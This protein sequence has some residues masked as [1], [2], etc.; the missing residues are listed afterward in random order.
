MADN[1]T[2]D[3][4]AT[5]ANY[6][7]SNIYADE[8]MDTSPPSFANTEYYT[9][10]TFQ[11]RVNQSTHDTL[12]CIHL[13]CQSISAHWDPLKQF[14]SDVSTPKFK[15][16]VIGLSEIFSAPE[17]LDFPLEGYHPLEFRTR[18]QGDDG[19]GGVGL[20]INNKLNYK[21]RTDLSIF[22]PHILESLFV[23]LKINNKSIIV[24]VIYRPNTQPK[25]DID[26]FINNMENITQQLSSNKTIIMGDFNIDLLKYNKHNKTSLFVDNMISNGMLPIINKPTRVTHTS[27]TIIDHIYINNFTKDSNGGIILTD[28][29]DHFATYYIEHG[30]DKSEN[31]NN[32]K[33]RQYNPQNI[34][35]FNELLQAYNFSEI[36]EQDCPNTAYNKFMN[37]YID[38]HNTA[39][40]LLTS[41]SK[42][43]YCK[44]D[45]WMTNGLIKS[46]KTKIKL[47]HKKLKKPTGENQL[48]YKTYLKIYN[49]T[50]R[51]A[52]KTY[53]AKAILDNRTNL[54]QTWKIINDI[55]QKKNDKSTLPDSF[56]INGNLITD[57]QTI[58]NEFN[59][60]FSKIGKKTN[61]LV[62]TSNTT[63]N[64]YLTKPTENSFFMNPTNKLEIENAVNHMKPKTSSGIDNISS[65]TIQ[66]TIY[67]ISEPLAH[68]FNLSFSKGQ[69]PT[70]MKTAKIIPIYKSGEKNQFNNYRPISLLPSVSKILEKLVSQRLVSF[71]NK[72]KLLYN[73]QYGFRQKHSTIHP[74]IQ[75]LNH[76]ANENDRPTGDITLSIF[77]DLSKA[78]DTIPHNTLLKKLEYYGIRGTCNNWFKDYLSKRKQQLYAFSKLSTTEQ[79]EC[80][81]PQG[82][83]LGPILF[84]I[85]IN[86]IHLASKFKLMSF[87]DDTTVFMSGHNIT[88]L[89]NH[90]NS[91]IN[92]L[93]VWLCANKLQLNIK[94]TKFAIFGPSQKTSRI[95]KI[96]N[97]KINNQTIEQFGNKHTE[98][99]IKFLGIQ[100]DE[101]LSWNYHIKY[102]SK[103]ISQG[104]YIL[105]RVKNF[106]PKYVL[107][108]LYYTLIDS[109]LVYGIQA[110]G[111]S[112]AVEK[113]F[114]LQKRAIRI[115][116][117]AEY[118]SHTDPLF[119]Q[120]YILKL[121]DIHQL[122]TSLFMYDFNNNNLPE[123][124]SNFH[125]NNTGTVHM[126][127]RQNNLMLTD[128]PRTN[129]TLKLP[130]HSF[131]RTWNTIDATI[132][133]SKSRNIF[134]RKLK[135]SI[136]NKYNNQVD[137]Q[138]QQ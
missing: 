83:I 64:S 100:I 19:R 77:L 104:L 138:Q 135:Q 10:E 136:I 28:V 86:D 109:H 7:F 49:K 65:K 129:F 91:E 11:T 51:M 35:R 61:D 3:Q 53:F 60:F 58:V 43:K 42:N 87:A 107:R 127:T 44:K 52:K 2:L 13:N 37:I 79:I 137:L 85:F 108:N 47:H 48:H 62:P 20:Y 92:Q 74:I 55:I 118:R 132:R 81:V 39:I 121:K 12:G 103:K 34:A 93:F 76:I 117:R 124:F 63:F 96:E 40:P 102:I 14:M 38:L 82:S 128:R 110:W 24:G 94:K 50:I 101:T 16:D 125:I 72:H 18:P 27:A 114:K 97:L 32:H 111:D 80:G 33:Y 73:N 5:N 75:L 84:I 131:P 36:Y 112:P 30:K 71:L 46:S 29:A 99:S 25:A 22:I 67:T 21:V 116:N 126:T 106:L 89:V 134:K 66:N 31:K 8:D 57:P 113:L 88:E 68:I 119:K 6:N 115:I 122:H 130:K 120:N 105:N 98:K 69:F 78:F 4:V 15:F 23:E 123:S 56:N 26:V 17:R 9:T 1:I 95:N 45:P 90:A 70:D 59:T 54:R 41:K 133:N